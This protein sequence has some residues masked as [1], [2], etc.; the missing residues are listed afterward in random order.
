MTILPNAA[1]IEAIEHLHSERVFH[2][3]GYGWSVCAEDRQAWPC[4]TVKAIDDAFGRE[5]WPNGNLKASPAGRD[6]GS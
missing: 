6:G 2:G 1:A 3:D 4:A 5:R